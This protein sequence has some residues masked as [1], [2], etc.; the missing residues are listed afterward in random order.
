[1]FAHCYHCLS[2]F[3]PWWWWC[4]RIVIIVVP[5]PPPES[6]PHCRP[7]PHCRCRLCLHIYGLTKE[8]S[9]GR[10]EPRVA[11]PTLL[12]RTITVFHWSNRKGVRARCHA[13]WTSIEQEKHCHCRFSLLLHRRLLLYL[14]NHSFSLLFVLLL[15]RPRMD[16]K[17]AAVSVS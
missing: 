11:N 9:E 15:Q 12:V 5:P 10:I 2:Q 6:P 17:T 16:H 3:L 4:S 7:R 13:A 8:P 14:C 1:M